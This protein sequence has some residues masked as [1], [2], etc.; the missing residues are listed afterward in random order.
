MAR[1]AIFD[2]DGTLS[3][4]DSLVSLVA[5]ALRARPRRAVHVVLA[6]PAVAW[7][8]P[9]RASRAKERLL[10]SVL[11]GLS[12]SEVDALGARVASRLALSPDVVASIDDHRRAGDD[13]WLASASI[14]PVIAALAVRVD[15]TGHV[16]TNLAFD[17]ERCTGR[18][19][20]E[21]CKGAEKLRRLDDALAAGWRA[22]ATAYSD[23]QVDKPM[24]DAAASCR[25]VRRGVLI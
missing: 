18:Y 16:A 15:A 1:V 2:V 21:N 14:D 24:M 13:V 6:L 20:G 19:A 10:T 5:A 11:A 23:S 8:A 4:R 12:R 25:W 22:T 9:R 17:G 7:H 3:R